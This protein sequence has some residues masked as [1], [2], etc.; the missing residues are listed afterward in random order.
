MLA[1]AESLARR[2]LE[3]APDNRTR[4]E[5]AYS[6]LFQR[7]PSSREKEAAIAYLDQ[8]RDSNK[9]WRQYAQVLLGT[10]EFMQVE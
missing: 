9:H 6:L 7:P 1:R 3:G 10:H 5:L 2:L 4:V 8:E